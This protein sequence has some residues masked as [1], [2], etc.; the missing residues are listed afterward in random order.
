MRRF[1]LFLLILSFASGAF[2]ETAEN[3]RKELSST[4]SAI[5][6]SDAR[7]KELARKTAKLQTELKRLQEE[8]AA[9]G[10][11]AYQQEQELN[12][13]ED[14]LVILEN[15]KKEKTEALKAR[16]GDLSS[17]IAA[18]VR[19]KQL[20]PEAIIAMP[21]KL[22]ETMEAAR[23]LGVVT[24]AIEEEAHSLKL[25]LSELDALEGRIY[26]NREIISERKAALATRQAQL[27][28][29]LKERGSLVEMLGGEEQEERQKIQK[30]T[31]KSKNLQALINSLQ[32]S[33]SYG[34]TGR[35]Q[36][37]NGAPREREHASLSA[38][39]LRP[40]ESAK[41]ALRMPAAGRIISHYGNPR[42]SA[43]FS[44][45]I[46]IETRAAANVVAPFDGEVVFAGPFRDYGRIVI[47]R[48]GGNYHSLLSGMDQINCRPGQYLLEGEPI[49]SMGGKSR[50]RL[51]MELREDGKPVDPSDWLKG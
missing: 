13:Y 35:K 46:V 40:F 34:W 28:A 37:G 16:Q 21:G 31:A 7:Q 26:R 45:G 39:K 41:G 23:A 12:S 10:K 49:G 11:D 47:I 20:P 51:Y 33:E 6:E 3:A 2:A 50:N 42:G 44:K 9:M 19:I 24:R 18:M 48:H 29:K 27:A 14:K 36:A 25:Q 30:L 22:D 43:T 4:L 15:Q 5:K 1:A 38:P 32:K 8:M 17:M